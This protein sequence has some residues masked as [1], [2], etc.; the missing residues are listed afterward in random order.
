MGTIKTIRAIRL[1]LD[2]E[3]QADM[4]KDLNLPETCDFSSTILAE[5]VKRNITFYHDSFR[6]VGTPGK[7]YLDCIIQEEDGYRPCACRE[8]Y[9]TE[10][11][12][13]LM[14]EIPF[15]WVAKMRMVEYTKNIQT[16]NC[17][18]PYTAF[19]DVYSFHREQR[20][21]NIPCIDNALIVEAISL[22]NTELYSSI[23][24]NS[25]QYAQL[26]DIDRLTINR[27]TGSVYWVYY[28][29]DSDSGG[30]I[31]MN[32]V[33]ADDIRSTPNTSAEAFFDYLGSVAKQEL[34]DCDNPDFGDTLYGILTSPPD[35]RGRTIAT[36]MAL[37]HFA[38][39]L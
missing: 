25:E 11:Y 37:R 14:L 15:A 28:N 31:V 39:M 22:A 32:T 24:L 26:L 6:F 12:Q 4:K 3:V 13:M 30:Q 2:A 19:V 23:G 18:D 7:G 38:T 20:F 35:L 27:N 17:A 29:P 9:T 34:C 8:L 16:G 33:T 21:T 5:W 36:K 10:I 1:P